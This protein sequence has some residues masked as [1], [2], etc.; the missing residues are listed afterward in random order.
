MERA[1]SQ[2]CPVPHRHGY[3]AVFHRGLPVGDINRRGSHRTERYCVVARCYAD[4]IRRV[5]AGGSLEELSNAGSLRTSL[6]LASRT[7]TRTC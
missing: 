5:R 4:L 6:C 3:G 1:D 7:R 2:L